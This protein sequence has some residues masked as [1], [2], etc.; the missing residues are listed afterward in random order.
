MI[1]DQRQVSCVMSQASREL[2]STKVLLTGIIYATT[3]TSF[4]NVY[5]IVGSVFIVVVSAAVTAAAAKTRVEVFFGVVEK[6]FG[7]LVTSVAYFARLVIELLHTLRQIQHV[8][9]S[10]L[11]RR[12][13]TLRDQT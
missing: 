4:F 10:M 11:N 13:K 12:Q 7:N 5:V 6:P 2:Q 3:F 9:L 1:F 8:L